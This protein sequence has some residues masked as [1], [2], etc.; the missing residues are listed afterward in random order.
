MSHM[1]DVP[2]WLDRGQWPWIARRCPLPEGR[3]HYVDEGDGKAVVLVHGT[4]TWGFEWRH[5]IAA[6]S[7]QARVIVPDH[8][9]FGLSDRP[10]GADYRPEAHAARFAAFM[11]VVVGRDPSHSWSTTSAAQSRCPGSW[12]T[13]HRSAR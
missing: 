12:R 1:T 3:L 5:V 9:G 10:A 11:D 13:P 7:P 2:G 8:L 4:P 6:L